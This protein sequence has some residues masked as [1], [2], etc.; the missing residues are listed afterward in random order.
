MI[1]RN[2]F[3][4]LLFNYSVKNAAYKINLNINFF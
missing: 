2:L 3:K 4:Y 1:F